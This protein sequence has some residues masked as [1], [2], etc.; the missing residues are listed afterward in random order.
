MKKLTKRKLNKLIKF[1]CKQTDPKGMKQ[2]LKQ[3]KKEIRKGYGSK[4]KDFELNCFVCQ[5]W[6]ALQILENAFDEDM[7]KID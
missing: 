3:L 7:L 1:L 2:L 5:V 4:C 6:L